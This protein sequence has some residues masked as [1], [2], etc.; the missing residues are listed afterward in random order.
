MIC[1]NWLVLWSKLKGRKGLIMIEFYILYLMILYWFN[2]LHLRPYF[3][4]VV[5]N[6]IGIGNCYKCF[7]LQKIILDITYHSRNQFL[8]FASPT[9][10]QIPFSHILVVHSLWLTLTVNKR[11]RTGLFLQFSM[12]DWVRNVNNIQGFT[13]KYLTSQLKWWHS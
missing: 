8:Y 1:D 3:K 13:L 10:W 2:F 11:L 5:C 12:T 7:L 4:L 6:F 9:D